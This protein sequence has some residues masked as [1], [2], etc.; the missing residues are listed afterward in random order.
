MA[1]HSPVILDAIQG[2]G[3]TLS[4][5]VRT[6]WRMWGKKLIDNNYV[7]GNWPGKEATKTIPIWSSKIGDLLADDFRAILLAI[8]E[9]AEE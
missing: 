2:S 1:T 4:R 5:H 8:L 6:E 7:I 3:S 9:E